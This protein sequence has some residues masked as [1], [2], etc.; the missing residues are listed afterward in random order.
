MDNNMLENSIRPYVV[1]RKNWLFNKSVEGAHATAIF[2]TLVETAKSHNLNSEHYL[3]YI[4]EKLP[5]SDTVEK[6]ES[7]LPWNLTPEQIIPD[8]FI[9]T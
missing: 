1:G 3:N 4:F 5:L 7:L 6:H 8:Y 9:N 2:Y